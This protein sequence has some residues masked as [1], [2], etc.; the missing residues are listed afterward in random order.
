MNAKVF[1]GYDAH[2]DMLAEDDWVQV[3]AGPKQYR[4][5]RGQVLCSLVR[6]DNYLVSV[7]CGRSFMDIPACYLSR[8]KA[9]CRPADKAFQR[10]LKKWIR[11]E[12]I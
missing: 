4:G 10:Q 9:D 7:L 2:G 1:A 12:V 11:G 3:I 8:I 5:R 6:G